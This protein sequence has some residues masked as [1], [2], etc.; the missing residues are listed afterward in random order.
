MSVAKTLLNSNFPSRVYKKRILILIL[1]I[2]SI[3]AQSQIPNKATKIIIQNDKTASENFDY[4]A[5]SLIQN[6]YFLDSKD[7][8]LFLIKTQPKQVNKWTGM[9]YL[10]IVTVDNQIQISGQMNTGQEISMDI[11]TIASRWEPISFKGLNK[12]LYKLAFNHMDSFAS[13][14]EGTKQYK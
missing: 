4:V 10:N 11:V 13:K 5:K 12:S 9:Y 7:K 2:C 1:L 3:T 6:D 14:L 8:E